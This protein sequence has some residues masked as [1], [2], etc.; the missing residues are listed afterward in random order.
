[1]CRRDERERGHD[2][3]ARQ[4]CGAGCELKGDRPIAHGDAVLHI[5]FLGNTPLEL[6]Q[7]G[8]VIG[9]PAAVENV[10]HATDETIHI[11]SRRRSYMKRRQ[12]RRMTCE[13]GEVAQR[14]LG[15]SN[16]GHLSSRTA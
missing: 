12:E 10:P 4:L 16:G 3:L 8:A 14:L 2:D 15:S 7:V 11:D 1:M 6:L 13:D 9:E 5:R